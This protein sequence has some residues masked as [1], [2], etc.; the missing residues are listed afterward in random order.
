MEAYDIGGTN[1]ILRSFWDQ[2]RPRVQTFFSSKDAR[3]DAVVPLVLPVHGNRAV[4]CWPDGWFADG[5]AAPYI[6]AN[7]ATFKEVQGPGLA[8][9]RGRHVRPRPDRGVL[10]APLDPGHVGARRGDPPGHVAAS[11]LVDGEHDVDEQ[12]DAAGLAEDAGGSRAPVEVRPPGPPARRRAPEAG[13]QGAA[14]EPTLCLSD[15]EASAI[16]AFAAAGGTVIADHLCGIFD[17]HGKA[18]PKARSTTS[19][20]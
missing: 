17:E 4:I 20:G 2:S 8:R 7:A 5:K 19:S 10:F 6:E 12:P 16:Q 11:E 14:P 9:H 3:R 15:A 18:R 1:E 13:L